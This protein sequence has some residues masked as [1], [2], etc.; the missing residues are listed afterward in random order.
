MR[1]LVLVCARLFGT[2]SLA[3]LF[4]VFIAVPISAEATIQT[5][6]GYVPEKFAD[7]GELLMAELNCVACHRADAA[8]KQRL[9]SKQGPV[10]DDRGLALT[11]QYLRR[12]FSDPQAVQPG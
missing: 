1:R 9:T 6:F 11:P 3:V 8:V 2:A 7:Q 4:L 10:L 5:G 12:F